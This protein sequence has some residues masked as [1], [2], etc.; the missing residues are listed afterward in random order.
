MSIENYL[1]LCDRLCCS[2]ISLWLDATR[3][4]P[5]RVTLKPITDFSPTVGKSSGAIAKR[6]LWLIASKNPPVNN[7]VLGDKSGHKRLFVLSRSMTYQAEIYR[8][9]FCRV[10]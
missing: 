8:W 6:S 10:G 9:E 5:L 4:A 3:I 1:N 2:V 7:P